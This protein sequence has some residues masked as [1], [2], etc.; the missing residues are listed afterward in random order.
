MT[1]N[2]ATSKRTNQAKGRRAVGAVSASN[3]PL[4]TDFET[5]MI[6]LR[7]IVEALEGEDGGLESAVA[8][9][10]RGVALQRR[11]EELLAAARLRVEE[12]LPSGAISLLEDEADEEEEP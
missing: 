1:S 12:L 9:Y 2:R 6:E 11:A 8:R 7:A 4:P 5:A 10:E 3:A